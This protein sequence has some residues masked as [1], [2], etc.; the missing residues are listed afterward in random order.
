MH[1]TLYH[2]VKYF[3][4]YI[5]ILC[6]PSPIS[7]AIKNLICNNNVRGLR[8]FKVQYVFSNLNVWTR[9]AVIMLE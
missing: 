8:G 1:V 2:E 3:Q 4:V 9:G 7:G 5:Q 6:L